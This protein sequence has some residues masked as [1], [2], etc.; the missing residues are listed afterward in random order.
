VQ[1]GRAARFDVL[2]VTRFA[3]HGKRAYEAGDERALSIDVGIR[4]SVRCEQ[5]QKACASLTDKATI[6]LS[7][8]Y[9]FDG[10]AFQLTPAS[11]PAYERLRSRAPD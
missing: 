8:R 11:R 5:D 4:S 9:T 6:D 1:P 7:L 2:D 10:T 3:V